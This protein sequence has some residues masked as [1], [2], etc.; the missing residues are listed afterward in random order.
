[1]AFM[2]EIERDPMLKQ[3]FLGCVRL[4]AKDIQE[5]SGSMSSDELYRNETLIPV[6][7]PEK[8]DYTTKPI[9]YV[10]KT[11]A[12]IIMRLL[13]TNGDTDIAAL[14][15]DGDENYTTNSAPN[16]KLCWPTEPSL[17]KEFVAVDTSPYNRGDCAVQNG[18]VYR[19][20]MDNNLTNPSENEEGWEPLGPTSIV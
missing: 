20:K 8:H 2:D 11:E 7:D 9:G 1:M 5:R 13:D 16:W 18:Y 12:G 3:V 4:V 15:L 14:S 6:Y 17:A 19:S 10:C